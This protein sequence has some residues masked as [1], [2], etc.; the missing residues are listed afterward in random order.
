VP[1]AYGLEIRGLPGV[2]PWLGTVEDPW[3]RVDVVRRDDPPSCPLTVDQEQA[4]FAMADDV[5]VGTRRDDDRIVVHSP[6]AIT[7]DDLLHPLIGPALAVRHLWSGR[8]VLHGG[9]VGSAEGAVVVLGGR[10]FGKSST[11]ADLATRSALEVFSDDLCVTDGTHAWTGPRCL[12]LREPTVAALGRSWGARVVRSATRWRLTL[13]AAPARVP[14]LG[15]VLLGWGD[16]PRAERVPAADALSL[17]V[18]ARMH[19]EIPSDPVVLLSVG[20]L[21]MIS[22]ERPRE[23]SSLAWTSA[24][25]EDWVGELTG[26]GTRAEP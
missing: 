14:L 8:Q 10:E 23:L 1:G 21:P 7:D 24:R 26:A 12:D 13:G 4:G 2:G 15:S 19:A 20:A 11:L 22:L 17:V 9:V 5:V 6:S 3:E 25:I 16:V 18:A